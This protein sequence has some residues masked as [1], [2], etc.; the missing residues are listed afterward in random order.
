[1]PQ[2]LIVDDQDLIRDRLVRFLENADGLTVAGATASTVEALNQI[3]QYRP[4]VVVLSLNIFSADLARLTQLTGDDMP[5]LVV[6]STFE[7]SVLIE[8]AL[9]L[10]AKG[11]VSTR[12]PAG[13]LVAAV[14]AV[15]AGERYLCARSSP[16]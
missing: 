3:H 5:P 6:L 1:M 16:G 13:E 12:S 11:Y 4:D 10:G 9:E 2:V 14:H 7:D 15:A 8:A